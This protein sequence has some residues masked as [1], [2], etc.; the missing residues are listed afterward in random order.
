MIMWPLNKIKKLEQSESYWKQQADRWER[1]AKRLSQY[2]PPPKCK[3]CGGDRLDA[4][5]AG[6]YEDAHR[7]DGAPLMCLDCPETEEAI[8]RWTDFHRFG[9]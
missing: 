4:D 5:P 3:R 9:G 2:A 7:W 6:Y 8:R 1:C